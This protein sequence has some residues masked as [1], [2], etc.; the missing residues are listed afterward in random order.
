MRRSRL[1]GC[2]TRTWTS[3][4]QLLVYRD[5]LHDDS[6]TAR[7]DDAVHEFFPLELSELFQFDG[8]KIEFFAEPKNTAKLIDEGLT[9]SRARCS[10]ICSISGRLRRST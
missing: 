3:Q 7:W 5:G 4:D 8:E 9:T 10:W 6:L 2:G 1:S